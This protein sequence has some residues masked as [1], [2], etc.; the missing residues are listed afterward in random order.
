M[1]DLIMMPRDKLNKMFTN[2]EV[3][4]AHSKCRRYFL[5]AR[6]MKLGIRNLDFEIN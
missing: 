5:N 1:L 3:H 2:M 4:K 6:F